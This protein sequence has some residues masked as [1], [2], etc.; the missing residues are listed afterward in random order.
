MSFTFI[1]AQ[2]AIALYFAGAIALRDSYAARP[3]CNHRPLKWWK[4]KVN[5]RCNMRIVL[6]Y[7]FIYA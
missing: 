5:M 7:T 4:L 2:R 3:L 6:R 1:V